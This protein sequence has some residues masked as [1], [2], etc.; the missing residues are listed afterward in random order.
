MGERGEGRFHKL[1]K[2]FNGSAANISE[3]QGIAQFSFIIYDSP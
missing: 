3:L 2:R 1:P